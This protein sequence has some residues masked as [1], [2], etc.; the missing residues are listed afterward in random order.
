MKALTDYTLYLIYHLLDWSL[1]GTHKS[2]TKLFLLALTNKNPKFC[3]ALQIMRLK[4]TACS[5]CA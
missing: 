2:R 5:A 1:H 3:E 4:A